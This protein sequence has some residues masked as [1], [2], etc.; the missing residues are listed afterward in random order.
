MRGCVRCDLTTPEKNLVPFKG[1]QKKK[2]FFYN[3]DC[4]QKL[5][6]NERSKINKVSDVNLV[7]QL[8][9]RLWVGNL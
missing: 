3:N 7:G 5:K 2:F 8:F 4:L 6:S 9:I 1:I